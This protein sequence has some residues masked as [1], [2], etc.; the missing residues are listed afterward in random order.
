ME[1]PTTEEEVQHL[2]KSYNDAL[3]RNKLLESKLQTKE[4]DLLATSA[5]HA[6]VVGELRSQLA[7]A[8]APHSTEGPRVSPPDPFNGD[9]THTTTFLRQLRTYF[10]A[11]PQQLTSDSIRITY[12]LSFMK[13]GHAA[14]W[15]NHIVEAREDA[16]RTGEVL[17]L[18]T[19]TAFVESFKKRFGELDAQRTAQDK[20]QMLRQD[21]STVEE[22]N[23]EFNELA[24]KT[25]FNETSL[26][27]YY[28]QTLKSWIA[29]AIYRMH[30]MPCTLEEW[31]NKAEDL[32]R[33]DRT[34]KAH[35]TSDGQH[36]TTQRA[37]MVQ[38]VALN[39]ATYGHPTTAPVPMELDRILK[40]RR[41][42]LCKQTGH[43]KSECPQA[44]SSYTI[45]TVEIE[46]IVNRT[47]EQLGIIQKADKGS[48][49]SKQQGFQ[50][51]QE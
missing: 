48:G 45:R 20:L 42:F 23:Q 34:R 7:H 19:W 35:K 41:C 38:R 12:A 33:Q 1:H 47:L 36:P 26:L 9:R 5:A 2:F 6:A 16:E 44:A 51:D 43:L 25:G 10:A 8:Q 32:D 49:D 4:Q 21:S 39:P 17:Q 15:A 46:D 50:D 14:T 29:D 3:Q 24:I 31:Q 30:P 37:T 22:L 11:Y 40:K 18:S 28:E 27:R 13:T